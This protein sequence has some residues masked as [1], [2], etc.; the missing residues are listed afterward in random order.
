MQK[1]AF[2]MVQHLFII[3]KVLSK[4]GIERNFLNLI[5]AIH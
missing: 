5:K 1:K 3:K 2:E 4:P